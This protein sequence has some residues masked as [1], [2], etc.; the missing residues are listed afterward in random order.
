[1]GGTMA[2]SLWHVGPPRE[3]VGSSAMVARLGSTPAVG[4]GGSV[5]K[6]LSQR[7][8]SRRRVT[9]LIRPQVPYEMRF[10][11]S[12]PLNKWN[13]DTFYS[14]GPEGYTDYSSVA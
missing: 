13:T 3:L 6:L 11:L 7:A 12:A 8:P 10:K 5:C 4:V 9:C 2:T 1:M 14:P